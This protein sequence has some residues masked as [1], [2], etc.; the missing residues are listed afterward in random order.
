MPP[1]WALAATGSWAVLGR[2]RV[3]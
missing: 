3:R 1:T 2:I